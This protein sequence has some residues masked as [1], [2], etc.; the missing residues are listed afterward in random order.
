MLLTK[1]CPEARSSDCGFSTSSS[2]S[3]ST[4]PAPA[5]DDEKPAEKA[6]V[7]ASLKSGI[8]YDEATGV[9]YKE[10]I[11]NSGI[12][13]NGTAAADGYVN[14]GGKYHAILMPWESQNAYDKVNYGISTKK[15]EYVYYDRTK[16][17]ATAEVTHVGVDPEDWYTAADGYHRIVQDWKLGQYQL[18]ET[19]YFNLV[20]AKDAEGNDIPGQELFGR[21]WNVLGN[22]EWAYFI[23]DDAESRGTKLE[24]NWPLV[25]NGG[26]VYNQLNA[27]H[28]SAYGYDPRNLK[29]G[30]EIVGN[31]I[32]NTN[33][34]VSAETA[35]AKLDDTSYGM[36]E[37]NGSTVYFSK[38]VSQAGAPTDEFHVG[39]VYVTDTAKWH[40]I[41]SKTEAFAVYKD[42]DYVRKGTDYTNWKYFAKEKDMAVRK[43][44]AFNEDHL[45]DY[46][47]YFKTGDEKTIDLGWTFL[48]KTAAYD[49][50]LEAEAA[51]K[52][53]RK[54][55]DKTKYVE[56][57]GV[58]RELVSRDKAT[59]LD[60]DY[61]MT[62]NQIY[63]KKVADP[64]KV[65]VD[66]IVANDGYVWA[67]GGYR[68]LVD[69]SVA[70][71]STRFGKTT[72]NGE[73]VIYYLAESDISVAT[74]SGKT[75]AKSGYILIDGNAHKVVSVLDAVDYDSAKYSLVIKDGK[76]FLQEK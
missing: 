44:E 8:K 45:A 59:T 58:W 49:S 28:A 65:T 12:N 62:G 19:K 15:N 35:E 41:V 61:L 67:E 9:Y 32:I 24:A 51:G 50:L 13:E 39:F 54:T 6:L 17:Y 3:G 2:N 69:Y 66:S 48:D 31:D 60:D 4:T 26:K 38:S 74:V 52:A 71:D 56:I 53:T 16:A 36:K 43:T 25:V 7:A 42:S 10:E 75:V 64:S 1:T 22:D 73:E 11:D 27:D 37:V 30:Y 5:K 47:K 40:K 70:F 33:A 68:K 23:N 29:A 20:C 57:N 18:S 55:L 76:A 14:V 72:V 46:R 63:E 34:P 21:A